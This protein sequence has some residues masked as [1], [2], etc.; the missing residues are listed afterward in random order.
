MYHPVVTPWVLEGAAVPPSTGWPA[1]RG[2]DQPS[3]ARRGRR[4]CPPGPAHETTRARQ[5]RTGKSTEIGGGLRNS[6]G[7]FGNA[8]GGLAWHSLS[9]APRP[10]ADGAPFVGQE[11][12]A[13]LVER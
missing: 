9:F 6:T 3:R 4:P 12:E 2:R 5:H 8:F 13:E 7:G 11:A 1:T 10:L